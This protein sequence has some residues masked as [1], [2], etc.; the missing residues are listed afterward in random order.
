VRDDLIEVLEK[1]IYYAELSNGAFDPTVG[2]LVRLWGIGTDNPHFPD[3]DE[4]MQALN[5]VNWRDIVIDREAG[6]V[7]LR[8]QGMAVDLG[9]IAKG[10]AADE[11]VRI[12][13]EAG[14]KRAVFD[15]GGDIAVIGW[16]GKKGRELLPWRIGL[17]N[18]LNERG[19]Y[20]GILNVNDKSVVTSGV[21]ENFIELDGKRYHHILSTTDGYP[22]ENGLLSVTVMADQTAD[23]DALS[24]AV[25]AMGFEK[26]KALIDSIP[27][28]EA[29][30]IFNDNIVKTTAGMF[31]I[32]VY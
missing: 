29:I 21:Y 14:V 19:T 24:T 10:Y 4:I 16:R 18:P 11:A 28:V 1:A 9:S 6:T 13:K 22:V 30:F 7:F 3:E 32:F 27:G 8:R 15:F 31:D 25:F 12:A 2:P 23:A 20:I 5:L 26:G 17:Q